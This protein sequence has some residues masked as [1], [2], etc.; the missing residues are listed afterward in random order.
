MTENKVIERTTISTELLSRDDHSCHQSQFWIQITLS[1]VTVFNNL[2]SYFDNSQ[3]SSFSKMLVT[4]TILVKAINKYSYLSMGIY[5]HF[6]HLSKAFDLLKSIKNLITFNCSIYPI[7]CC[8]TV[9]GYF[10]LLN[11][12]CIIAWISTTE[13]RNFQ[14]S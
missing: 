10:V 7:S 4:F 12:G 3:C 1:T 6:T 14:T 9:F 5:L 8:A 2:M 11:S 13:A